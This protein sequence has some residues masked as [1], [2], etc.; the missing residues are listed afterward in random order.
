[1]PAMLCC[2]CGCPVARF[3]RI[4]RSDVWAVRCWAGHVFTVVIESGRCRL[5]RPGLPP[6]WESPLAATEK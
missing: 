6:L 4:G 5:A 3:R 2:P 1:M